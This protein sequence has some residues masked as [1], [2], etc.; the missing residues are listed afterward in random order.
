MGLAGGFGLVAAAGVAGYALGSFADK[1]LG[2]SD[3]LSDLAMSVLGPAEKIARADSFGAGALD[4]KLASGEIT[5]E[6]H[7]K[8]KDALVNAFAFRASGFV[9]KEISAAILAQTGQSVKS[10]QTNYDALG[11]EKQKELS[12]IARQIAI[13]VNSGQEYGDLADKIAS[14]IA[15]ADINISLGAESIQTVLDEQIKKRVAL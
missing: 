10:Q 3:G 5:Q 9:T 14:A 7:T 1:A 2:L 12:E 15:G 13:K 11:G 4:D 8:G 6:Q